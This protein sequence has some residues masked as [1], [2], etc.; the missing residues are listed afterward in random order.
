MQKKAF[1]KIQ[2][3]FMI[4]ILQ[5]IDREGNYLIIVKAIHE[6]STANMILNGEELKVFPLI[7][8]NIR[9]PTVSTIIQQF[10][11]PS[12]GNQRRK[13]IKGIQIGKKVKFSLF[14]D[15]MLLYIKNLKMP[16]ENYQS[17]SVIWKSKDT[18]LIHKNPLH[19][20][21]LTMKS[22]KKS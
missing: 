15:D 20:Y 18:K 4:K 19:S 14:V 5:K 16:P 11:S 22:R 13:E 3:P 7:R 8:I 6:K 1:D 9:V 21:T 17:L 10:G 2:Y 12:H